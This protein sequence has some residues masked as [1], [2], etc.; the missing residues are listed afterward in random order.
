MDALLAK[1]VFWHWFAFAVFL[2]ILDV[3]VGANFLFIWCGLSAAV[4]GILLL[5]LPLTWE[6]QFLIFGLGVMASLLVWRKLKKRIRTDNLTLNRRAQYYMGRVFTLENPIVNGRG[7]VKVDD[8]MWIV[9]GPDMP[10]GSKIKVIGVDG[11]VLKIE[12]IPA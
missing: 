9:E 12:Q 4:V 3:A 10:A 1:L 11:V 5:V 6:I 8:T 2:I 7:K